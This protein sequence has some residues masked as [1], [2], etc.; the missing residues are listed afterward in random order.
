[1]SGGKC[2]IRIGTSRAYYWH[3]RQRY[4][5]EQL[6]KYKWFEYY[7]RDFDTVEINNTFYQL[8][9]PKSLKR[10]YELADKNFVYAVKA[11]RYIT[12]IKKLRN[13]EE[14]LERFFEAVGL[15]GEKL[16]PVLYQLPPSLHKNLELLEGFLKLLPK[17]QLTA[18][19]F[20][21]ASWFCEETFEVL[22]K[23]SAGFCVHDMLGLESPKVVTGKIIYIRFHGP[24]EKYAGKYTSKALA[25]WAKWIDEHKA[26][27]KGVY[28]YFNNDAEANA[29]YNAMELRELLLGQEAKV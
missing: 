22:D 24:G 21:H 3:W 13:A 15:L 25:G 12:H 4:Y 16:G 2:D 7:A 23:G 11:N 8:P 20:R 29:V 10:W 14:P 27:V 17:G 9:K 26:R 28:A 19:E 1:M 6:P 18:F 5:P